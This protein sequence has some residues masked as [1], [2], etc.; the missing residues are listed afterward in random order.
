MDNDTDASA[1]P[2]VADDDGSELSGTESENLGWA[3][4]MTQI[5]DHNIRNS[6]I[7]NV[8]QEAQSSLHT[9]C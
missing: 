8:F 4:T 7:L 2:D 5:K 1:E 6:V 9:R 3:R